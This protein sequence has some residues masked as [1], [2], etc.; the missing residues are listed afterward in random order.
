MLRKGY[1]PEARG[2]VIYYKSHNHELKVD[3]RLIFTLRRILQGMQEYID[4][5]CLN[6]S[7]FFC[8]LTLDAGTG[9]IH[10]F[11][12]FLNLLVSQSCISNYLF[13][14]NARNS[15]K[16]LA[17]SSDSD[18]SDV[19]PFITQTKAALMA[20][21]QLSFRKT[22]LL[23]FSG[24]DNEQAVDNFNFRT[25]DLSTNLHVYRQRRFRAKA[26]YCNRQGNSV[27]DWSKN[28]TKHKEVNYMSSWRTRVW[29]DWLK[30]GTPYHDSDTFVEP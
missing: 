9:G 11:L 19:E 12:A 14:V 22:I 8:F 4:E 27:E 30:N 10:K 3:K 25:K 15:L 23:F 5:K 1:R 7:S 20:V 28:T 17:V 18:L 2:Y 29:N 21:L 26:H 6:P 13:V 24:A 16:S